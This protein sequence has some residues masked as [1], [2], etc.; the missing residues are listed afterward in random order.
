MVT[1][2]D[3]KRAF[4]H[5]VKNTKKG[6]IDVSSM[7]DQLVTVFGKRGNDITH[8]ETAH[9]PKKERVPSDAGQ[10]PYY[11]SVATLSQDGQLDVTRWKLRVQN[12]EHKP[13]QPMPV[14]VLVHIPVDPHEDDVEV[15][16]PSNQDHERVCVCCNQHEHEEPDKHHALDAEDL[17]GGDHN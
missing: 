9:Q 12:S 13:V 11:V 2:G 14:A 1:P 5:I 8:G 10:Q 16:T 3:R 4:Q 6:K 15:E 7:R 17:H